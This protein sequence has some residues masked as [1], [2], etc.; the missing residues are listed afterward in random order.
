MAK[1]RPEETG[2]KKNAPRKLFPGTPEQRTKNWNILGF[3][4][5]LVTLPLLFNF[6]TLSMRKTREKKALLTPEP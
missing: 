4:G 2:T 3:P 1:N 5:R 6:V